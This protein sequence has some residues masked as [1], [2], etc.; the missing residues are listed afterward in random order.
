MKKIIGKKNTNEFIKKIE[1]HLKSTSRQVLNMN[2]REEILTIVGQSFK[3]ILY[4]DFV[5][6]ALNRKDLLEPQYLS[7][8]EELR[9]IFPYPSQEVNQILYH[10]SIKSD[11]NA[12]ATNSILSKYFEDRQI[13]SWF[14]IPITQNGSNLGIIIAGYYDG[15]PFIDEMRQ[16]FKELGEY[17]AIAIDMIQKNES[18]QKDLRIITHSAHQLMMQNS[19]DDLLENVVT[20]SG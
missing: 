16:V 8:E 13:D 11:D 19:I 10:Q 6:I 9:S 4:S 1:K 7:G 12:L 18:N 15:R 3:E 17:I 20:L 2:S 5:C 14:T